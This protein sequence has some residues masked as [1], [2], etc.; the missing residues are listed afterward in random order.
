MALMQM[1]HSI[2][3]RKL[4]MSST[5]GLLI[6]G[7]TSTGFDSVAVTRDSTGA[8]LGP[9]HW[10]LTSHSSSGFTLVE[11]LNL[12]STASATSITCQPPVQSASIIGAPV[13]VTI[14]SSATTVTISGSGT[15]ILFGSTVV[16][17][18]TSMTLTVT[19]GIQGSFFTLYAVSTLMWAVGTKNIAVAATS[20]ELGFI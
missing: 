7:G 4:G 5:F 16:G 6:S 14:A 2:Y 1:L 8:V 19:N 9:F 12:V 11:G 18:S 13:Y 15:A 3:G 10:P 20:I 17:G